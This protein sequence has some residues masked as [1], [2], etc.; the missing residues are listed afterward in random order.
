MKA[1]GWIMITFAWTLVLS[2]A[3]YCFA[4]ILKK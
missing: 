4:R 3:V 2:L 1:G